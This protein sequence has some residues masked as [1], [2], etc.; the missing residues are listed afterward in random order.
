M[1]STRH[2]VTDRIFEYVLF[3]TA[4]GILAIVAGIVWSLVTLSSDAIEST[5]LLNFLTGTTWDPVTEQ[6]GALPALY[7]TI[8][9]S[10][11][12]LVFAVPLGFGTAI[13]L[14]EVANRRIAAI[15]TPLVDLLA[16]IPSVIYG[17]WGLF[18]LAPIMREY[19]QPTIQVFLG[20]LPLFAGPPIG[21]GYLTGGIILAIM[22]LPVI[23]SVAR[24]VLAA[25]PIS[26]RE[27]AIALGATHFEVIT[28]VVMPSARSGLIGA[29]VLGLGRAIG[30]T[31]AV[32]MVIGNRYDISASIFAPGYTLAAVIANEF[33][34]AFSPVYLSALGAL[35]LVL[36]GTTLVLNAGARALVYFVSRKYA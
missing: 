31:M 9:T 27:A 34:E 18:V 29:V 4:S 10:A 35:A 13:F 36:M 14:S 7:G 32:T 1:V 17:L 12:A 8:L 21:V 15:V 16:A 28:R 3:S 23:V 5:G 30:E 11:I 2:G 24:E 19:V 26:H 33:A 6:F 25:V 22:I 20:D